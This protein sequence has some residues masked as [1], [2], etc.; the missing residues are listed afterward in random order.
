MPTLKM[1]TKQKVAIILLIV[2]SNLFAFG[3]NPKIKANRETIK[4]QQLLIMEQKKALSKQAKLISKLN[5]DVKS[6]R[7]N[8]SLQADAFNSATSVNSKRISQ[9]ENTKY[10]IIKEVKR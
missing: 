4:K 8:L 3:E 2:S 10:K 7:Y 5:R 6:F 1:K 9:I